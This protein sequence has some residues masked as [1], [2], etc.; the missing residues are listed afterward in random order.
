MI[1][2]YPSKKLK[3]RILLDFGKSLKMSL[4]DMLVIFR[5]AFLL[6]TCCLFICVS[7]GSSMKLD[8][9]NVLT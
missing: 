3:F 1:R 7:E 5:A 4:F 6:S 9:L 8:H 2:V